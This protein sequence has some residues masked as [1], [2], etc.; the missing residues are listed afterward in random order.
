M[1]IYCVQEIEECRQ[2]R[3]F[4]KTYSDDLKAKLDA[5]NVSGQTNVVVPVHNWWVQALLQQMGE[6]LKAKDS[7]FLKSRHIMRENGLENMTLGKVE[8]RPTMRWLEGV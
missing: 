7:E 4:Y 3:D 5:N 8:G 1:G 2:Q 6:L